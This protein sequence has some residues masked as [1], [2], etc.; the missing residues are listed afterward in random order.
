[1]RKSSLFSKLCWENW[2]VTC[3]RMK[4][5]HIL[6]LY[7]KINSKWIKDLNV[8]PE[9]LKLLKGNIGRTLLDIN[10]SKSLYNPP[11][12]IM[13]IKTKGI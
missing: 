9:T 11:P 7:T 5:V 10:H 12:R 1:M 2:T 4:L 13:E 3:K 8:R 6:T